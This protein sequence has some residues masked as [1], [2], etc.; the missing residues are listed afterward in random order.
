[1]IEQK[2]LDWLNSRNMQ[3]IPLSQL[4]KEMKLSHT[5]EMEFLGSLKYFK[6]LQRTYKIIDGKTVCYLRVVQ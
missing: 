2:V 6:H 4:V 1:M 3:M 5:E